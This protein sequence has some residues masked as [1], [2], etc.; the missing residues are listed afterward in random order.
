M[1]RQQNIPTLKLRNKTYKKAHGFALY[2]H[3]QPP[4]RTAKHID[5]CKSNEIKFTFAVV[6]TNQT[7]KQSER[8]KHRPLRRPT[9]TTQSMRCKD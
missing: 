8:F 6:D 3:Q 9:R 1:K 7:T 4:Q 2:P 5:R